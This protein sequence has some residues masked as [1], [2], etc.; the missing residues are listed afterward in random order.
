MKLHLSTRKKGGFTLVELMVSNAILAAVAAICSAPLMNHMQDGDRQQ[1]IASLGHV[2]KLLWAFKGDHGDYPCDRTAEELAEN[3]TYDF[4][5]LKGDHSNAY[6]RQLFYKHTETER[7]FYGALQGVREGDGHIANGQALERGENAIAYVMLKPRAGEADVGRRGVTSS[8]A[9]LAFCGVAASDTP[10]DG[11]NVRFD[12]ASF[13]GHA[14]VAK[15]DGSIKD[16]SN[17]L[18]ETPD[19][20]G[21]PVRPLFPETRRGRD[22]SGDYIVLTPDL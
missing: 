19:G 16:L 15:V 10:W 11:A 13:L 2:Q 5:E 6:F 3:D 9:P 1:A 14:Y 12:M 7:V 4:G 17:E 8:N 22:T 20:T 18:T 21:K